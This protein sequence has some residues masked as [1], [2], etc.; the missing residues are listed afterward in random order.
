MKDGLR[1]RGNGC[2]IAAI[3]SGLQAP[4]GNG[5]ICDKI[6]TGKPNKAIVDLI[7]GQHGIPESTLSRMIMIG[8]RCDTDVALGN[9]AGI[10]S[11]LVLTG[12]VTSEEQVHMYVEQK[13]IHRP[14][15][16]L[17]SFGEDI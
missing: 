4:G 11:C 13:D 10:A 9:N 7:R 8:D 15:Y 6:V 12:V 5:L 16:V 2:I 17:K 1:Y 14:T 3:E